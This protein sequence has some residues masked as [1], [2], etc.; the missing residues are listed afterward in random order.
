MSKELFRNTDTQ[1]RKWLG[2]RSGV[3]LRMGRARGKDKHVGYS[4]LSLSIT[5]TPTHAHTRPHTRPK[6]RPPPRP[7]PEQTTP[8]PQIPNSPG[9]RLYKPCQ[10]IKCHWVHDHTWP[11]EFICSRPLGSRDKDSVHLAHGG[12][13]RL[14]Y[15][16][17]RVARVRRVRQR[18]TAQ[19]ESENTLYTRQRNDPHHDDPSYIAANYN[20]D[21]WSALERRTRVESFLAGRSSGHPSSTRLP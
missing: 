10:A 1:K 7:H 11:G 8:T 21:S 9:R 16:P 5:H 2:V 3:T 6:S 14:G 15:R 13:G 4:G 20:Y 17:G 12:S 18:E 19:T